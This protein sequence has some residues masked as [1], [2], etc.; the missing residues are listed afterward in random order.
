MS[1]K[2]KILIIEDDELFSNSLAR[3]L[4]REGFEVDKAKSAEEALNL[5][6]KK[7]FNLIISDVRLGEGI[8]GIETVKRIKELKPTVKTSVII[9]TAYSDKDAP[10]RAIQIDADDFIF[11]PIQLDYF[12]LRVKKILEM[13]RLKRHEEEY[14]GEIRILKEK[15]T[16]YNLALEDKIREKT[17]EL[18]L[19][20]EI[21]RELTSSLQLEEV[22]HTIVERTAD[23]L[24]VERCSLLLLDETKNELF[25]AAAKGIPHEVIAKTRIKMGEKISGWVLENKISILVEDIE[26]DIRFSKRNEERYF[27]RSFISVPLVFKG[28][29]I[30]VINV[31]NKRSRQIFTKEELRLVEGIADQAAVAV[32]NARLYSNLRGVYLQIIATLTSIIEVKD[33]YTKGHSERVT[34]YAVELAKKMG[35]S[36]SQIE[37]V[38]L[39]CQL[40]DLGK[41]GIHENI[42]TKP[43]K[44]SKEEW[45]EIKLHPLKG[46]EILKPLTFLNDVIRLIEQHHER[47]DGKGYPYG[48]RG[49]DID[50]RAR[51]MAVAD[52]FDAMT[53][54]RPYAKA[55]SI[56]EAI[57]ELERC[58]GTQFDPEVV[59]AFI[60]LIKEKPYL[61]KK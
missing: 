11:K 33:H 22:L 58:K 28:R 56:E 51:I 14:I 42:L 31:N 17:T 53:T 24:D 46:A 19:L 8:D 37:I 16:Q 25:I 18:T 41:I 3:A 12:M 20:F 1:V 49:G 52:S 61:F 54:D 44:L 5:V 10:I 4:E 40:H 26:K 38:R 35:F 7:N 45:E 13:A 48:N 43:G 55:L 32:E 34:T 57:K 21:G 27:T 23:V 9:V 47:F 60:S 15:L 39:A 6:Q 36:S 29:K 59:D 30:G 2:E 50:L